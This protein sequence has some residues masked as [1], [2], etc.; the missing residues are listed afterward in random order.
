MDQPI[1]RQI[2]RLVAIRISTLRGMMIHTA[3]E[4]LL[5]YFR[6]LHQ[7]VSNNAIETMISGC[8]HRM[9]E[10]G[11][12]S[13]QLWDEA[14]IEIRESLEHKD[15]LQLYLMLLDLANQSEFLEKIIQPLNH[16]AAF[17]VSEDDADRFRLFISAR[18]PSAG[19]MTDCLVFSSAQ[20]DKT[21]KL[22]GRWI[23]DRIQDLPDG[24]NILEVEGLKGKLLV[25][26]LKPIQSFVVRCIEN[27]GLEVDGIRLSDCRFKIL[28]AGSSI[29]F[30]GKSIL[31]FSEIKQRYLQQN[32]RRFISLSINDLQLNRTRSENPIHSLTLREQ[33]GSLIGI[34]GKEGSG[35]TTLLKLLA[36]HIAPE[37][38]HI[39]INGYDLQKNRY[40]LKDII[41]HV[42]EEDLLFEELTVYDN[43]LMNARLFYSSLP[44]HEIRH[45]VDHLLRTLFMNDIRDKVVGNVLNKNLQPG[46]RRILNIALE[47]LREPQILIVDNALSGLS[48]SDSAKV[49]RILHQYTLEGNLVIT[50]ITQVNSRIFNYFDKVW[51]MDEGGYPVYT[52]P[53][54][55]AAAYLY[56]KLDGTEK[57][58]EEVDPATLIDLINLSHEH[59]EHAEVKRIL[60]PQEW[61]RLYLASRRPE[62]AD[63]A[64]KSI[65]PARLIKIPNLEVQFLIFS[66]R[67]FLCK[68]SRIDNLI[69]TLLSGPLIALI[70]GFFLRRA[71]GAEYSFS[72]NDNLPAYQFIS[73]MVALFMGIVISSGE[74]LKDRNILRKEQFLELSRFSYIN[75]KIVFLLVI[76][77]LQSFLYTATGNTILEIKGMTGTYWIVLFSI[78]CFGVLIGLLFSSVAHRL[79]AI[80]QKL[81]P[82]FLAV[83]V[84]FGGAVIPYQALNLEKT[85]YVPILGEL[86]ISRWGY[87]AIS[88]QQFSRNPYQ[89]NYF[90]LDQ[91]INRSDY[92]ISYLLP[93][94]SKMAEDCLEMKAGNDSLPKYA[95]ILYN[96]LKAFASEPEVFPFEF[97]ASL[98]KEEISPDLISETRDYLTYLKLHFYE[99]QET[100]LAQKGKITLHLTDSLGRAELSHL[101]N[102]YYNE[103][104][105]EIVT[106]SHYGRQIELIGDRF[107]RFRD[108]I[109]QTPVSNYGRAVMFTPS[110]IFNG[111]KMNTLWFNISIIWIFSFVIYLLLLTDAINFIRR[112]IKA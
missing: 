71:E 4:S 81:V 26:Y 69:Y 11:M 47:I 40:L 20:A 46:Q 112:N 95:K 12:T 22:E 15:Q 2:I 45:K 67:N 89:K 59:R 56:K 3:N 37:K 25:M 91:D 53:T 16:A 96:E 87:E 65:F 30:N 43:L 68:F 97:L 110:K 27:E 77:A 21:E 90:A 88:V 84:L 62:T 23:E 13:D 19:D 104:L 108:G 72:A 102:E 35:K 78:A 109:Y 57:Q 66:L 49:I 14:M 75:S 7:D 85:K 76:V 42:P 83:Q 111:Q 34:L 86:T 93:E 51:I 38:G 24:E 8:H 101:K 105:E 55:K 74:I 6:I 99:K 41:G 10:K 44:G 82:V 18:D 79:N 29:H 39:E 63:I 94:L 106:N 107:I 54:H 36:G 73:I 9:E 1:I 100:Y 61:H 17:G 70:L 64:R 92:Y 98:K 103:K 52:G 48:M 60:S 31:T 32:T 80:D 5:D 28:G 33:S 50:S 58:P